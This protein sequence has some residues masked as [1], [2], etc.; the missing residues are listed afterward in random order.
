MEAE[1]RL[2]LE[3]IGKTDGPVFC[4][5]FAWVSA[6]AVERAHHHPRVASL[7]EPMGMCC[8]ERGGR[9]AMEFP[10]FRALE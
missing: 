8:E 10:H 3:G 1:P 2:L 9:P 4:E 6:E 5:V 7:W